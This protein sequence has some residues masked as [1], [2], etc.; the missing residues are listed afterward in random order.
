MTLKFKISPPSI[1]YAESTKGIYKPMARAATA[2][3]KDT[4]D[5]AKT[6]GRAS[7]AAAGFSR[8]WQGALRGKTFPERGYSADAAGFIYSKIPYSA[9]FEEGGTISGSPFLWVP[10]PNM[11]FAKGGRRIQA[12]DYRRKIG[13]PLYSIRRSGGKPLLGANVRMTDKRARKAVSLSALRRGRN[14]GG[15]GKVRLVPLYVGIP[16][17]HIEKKFNVK[18]AVETAMARLPSRYYQ[19]FV[20][21]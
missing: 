10:L 19:H 20:D 6:L 15:R 5:Q 3:I 14:P 21:D 8:K 11:P 13:H 16:R 18:A 9:I 1:P 17:A 12:K 7:I 4:T 2:A